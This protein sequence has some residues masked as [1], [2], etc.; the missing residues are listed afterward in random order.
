MRKLILIVHTSLDG[1]VAGV[2][3]E[4]DNFKTSPENLDFV[5]SLTGEADA[6]LAGRVSYQML[7]SF[8]PTARDRKEATPAEVR[9]SNWYNDVQKIVLSRTLSEN[10]ER[11]T[12]ISDNV[13]E[14]IHEIK[15]QPGKNILMF[16]SPTAF[17]TLSS[18]NLIDDY[19]V[20]QYPV[21]FGKGIPFFTRLNKVAQLNL[22][23]VKRLSNGEIA[24][25]YGVNEHEK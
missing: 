1:Y 2:N 14:R 21:L 10:R 18:L 3:G 7:D 17:E 25:H 24:L 9:Y 13:S 23:D 16:G 22:L 20:I 19:W 15:K 8:W 5:C 6:A 12:I 4:F 11:T